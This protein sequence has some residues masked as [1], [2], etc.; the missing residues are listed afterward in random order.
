MNRYL[1]KLSFLVQQYQH[2]ETG[3]TMWHQEGKPLP[4]KGWS[5]VKGHA[6]YVRKGAGK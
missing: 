5:K 4:G 3:R 1:T 6:K 2:D